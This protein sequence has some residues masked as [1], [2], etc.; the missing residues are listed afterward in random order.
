MFLLFL[1]LQVLGLFLRFSLVALSRWFAAN[2]GETWTAWSGHNTIQH[3]CPAGSVTRV[4]IRISFDGDC[5]QQEQATFTSRWDTD[6]YPIGTLPRH[7]K[8]GTPDLVGE[9]Q[10][11]VTRTDAFSSVF[12]G[13]FG[14]EKV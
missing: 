8:P 7:V 12:Q 13:F 10:E 4:D 6:D 1:G 3:G 14:P 2:K 11:G 9:E 5:K